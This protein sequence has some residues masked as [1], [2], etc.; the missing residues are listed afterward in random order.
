M[1]SFLKNLFLPVAGLALAATAATAAPWPPVPGDLILG[2]QAT[3]GAGATT[4]VFFNLGPAHVLRDSP[5]PAGTLV[6]LNAELTAAYGAD[7]STRTDLYFGVFANRSNATPSGIGSAAPENGDPARTIYASK[8]VTTAGTGVPWSGYSVSALGSAATPHQ[9]QIDAV[10]NIAANS[11]QVMTLDQATNTVE[12]NN[13]WSRWNPT[14]GAAFSIFTGGIQANINATA[15]LVDVFRIVSTTGSGSYVTTVSLAANGNVTAARAGAA[16]SYYT[17]TTNATNGS[18]SGGG[19]G[20]L[21]ANGSNAK[22]TAAPASG[23][24]FANWTGDASGSANPLTLLMDGNKTVTANFLLPTPTLTSPTSTGITG[25]GATL[26]GNITSNGGQSITERGV[27]FA[28]N[29]S[30]AN[31]QIGGSGVTK[32]TAVGTGTGVFTTSVSGLTAGSTYAFAAYA[33]SSLGTGYSTVGRFTTDSTITFTGGVGTLTDRVI[34][35]GDTQ[36][37]RLTIAANTAADFTGTGATTNTGWE[38]R[39]NSNAVVASGTGN[40]VL[41]DILAAGDYTLRLTNIGGTAET[42]SLVL[43]A[44]T[45]A[46]ASPFLTSPTST[47]ITGSGA[48]LGGNITSDG[49]QALTERGVVVAL[50]SSNPNPQIGGTGVTKTTAVGTGTGVF[51]TSVSSLSA[52]STYAFAAYATNAAGTGYSTVGRFTTD[53]TITCAGGVGTLTDRV[54]LAGDTQLFR[55]T[56][57]TDSEADFSGTGATN[58]GWQLRDGSN[59][60][61]ASGAGNLV[62][63]EILTSGDYT[64]RLTNAGGT[65]ETVSLNLA[66]APVPPTVSSPTSTGIT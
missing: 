44:S 27:V 13:S 12:W 56:I 7:W 28:L 53:F 37:F 51:T 55:F 20:I 46:P 22:L 15:A 16:A 19:A 3:G 65:T 54:I 59:A 2:V 47:G 62:Y 21:Y 42:V 5:N 14:P 43:D 9:G 41:N 63:T 49:N 33:T 58:T 30:N 4:N 39:N 18:V 17:V 40:I 26:G 38:L 24:V 64:L 50:N 25:T 11:N 61:V 66:A 48:T 45:P 8:G 10:D 52:G 36:L 60:L 6:N 35:A 32:T 57:P 29:S 34:L 1:K 23:Y 31:P